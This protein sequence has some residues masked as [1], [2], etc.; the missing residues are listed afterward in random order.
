DYTQHVEALQKSFESEREERLTA[1]SSHARAAG[2][3][4]QATPMGIGIVPVVG[5]QPMRDEQFE[6]LSPTER[7]AL[8]RKRDAIDAEMGQML[9]AMRERERTLR[10]QLEQIEREVALHAVGGIVADLAERYDDLPDV[11]AHLSAL[12]EDVVAHVA[13]FRALAA[14]AM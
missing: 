14:G 1:I 8:Q 5:G 9:K 2:F 6:A 10:E 11:A 4:L 3:V 13:L 7:E 12:R